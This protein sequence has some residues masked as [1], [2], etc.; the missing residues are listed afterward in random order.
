[1]N[2][3]P[4]TINNKPTPA[5]THSTTG[6]IKYTIG[7]TS[8]N[9][10]AENQEP[11]RSHLSNHEKIQLGWTQYF[12]DLSK[13]GYAI[14]HLTITYNEPQKR[15]LTKNEIRIL[16]DKFYKR[17][18]LKKIMGNNYSRSNKLRTLPI[19]VAFFD[20]H[21]KLATR[22][23]SNKFADRHHIHAMVAA[24]QDTVEKIEALL[25]TNTLKDENNIHCGLIKTTHINRAS[26]YCAAYASKRKDCYDEFLIYGP[27]E[28]IS[29][30]NLTH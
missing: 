22:L 25:G 6:A 21:E 30:T 27:P 29:F 14:Y 7:Y 28:P 17:K 5:T 23:H 15:A 9:Q 19:T 16:F 24:H 26:E 12:N 13:N 8:K 3:I 4:T 10:L 20:K 1:M 2:L 18:L 11:T